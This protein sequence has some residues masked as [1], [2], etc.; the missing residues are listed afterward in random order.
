MRYE[1]TKEF[2]ESIWFEFDIQWWVNTPWSRVQQFRG[3]YCTKKWVLEYDD[4]EWE[5]TFRP[6]NADKE[7]FH[8]MIDMLWPREDEDHTELFKRMRKEHP[9][10]LP[11]F[12]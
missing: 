4:E 1:P 12:N 5:F 7:T 11:D 3:K 9:W 6:H 8:K 2:L 10:V